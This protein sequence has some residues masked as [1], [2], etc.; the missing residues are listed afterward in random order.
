VSTRVSKARYFLEHFYAVLTVASFAYVYWVLKR[1]D[2]DLDIEK[3]QMQVEGVRGI[4]L[5]GT[6][7]FIAAIIFWFHMFGDFFREEP[8]RYA[9]AWGILLFIGAHL[10]ALFYFF[11]IWRPRHKLP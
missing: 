11:I 10:G 3:L 4:I 7:S 6:A 1:F 9:P 2:L 5:A 8:K